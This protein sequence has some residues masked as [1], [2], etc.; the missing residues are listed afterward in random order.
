MIPLIDAHK[1]CNLCGETKLISE[2]PPNKQCKYGVTGTCRIC[3]NVKTKQ[4]YRDN[5]KR[6]QQ[7]ANERNRYRKLKVVNHFGNKCFDCKQSFPQYVYEF[8]HLDPTQKDWNPSQS[9][10]HSEER[11]WLELNKCIMLC[12]NCHK[13]R[14]WGE[15]E[16]WDDAIN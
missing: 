7:K 4:W 10:S 16:D 3:Y 11:M 13:I 1:T 15:R 9:L 2:F 12:A 6:R 8:H 5:K 14:H